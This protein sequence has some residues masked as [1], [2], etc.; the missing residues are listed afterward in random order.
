MKVYI[1]GAGKNTKKVIQCINLN[2][3]NVLGIIDNNPAK[4]E[5]VLEGYK[6]ISINSIE[7]NYDY[8]IV[9]AISYD[10]II[11]QIEYATILV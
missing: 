5:R 7:K 8:I 10:S 11:Y 2:Y 4:Q 6:I 9:S 1:W 3:I